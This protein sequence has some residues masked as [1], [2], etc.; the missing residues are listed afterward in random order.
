M[1]EIELQR[2]EKIRRIQEEGKFAVPIEDGEAFVT[3]D[4]PD[5]IQFITDSELLNNPSKFAQELAKK[6]PVISVCAG[7]RLTT[8]TDFGYSPEES[9]SVYCVMFP[10]RINKSTGNHMMEQLRVDYVL[11]TSEGNHKKNR[12]D[13]AYDR[14]PLDSAD[15][16]EGSCGLCLCV[17][18]K[19]GLPHIVSAADIKY[20]A[21]EGAHFT[22]EKG[23]NI[24]ITADAVKYFI[25]NAEK[26]SD[27]DSQKILL[28]GYDGPVD[29]EIVEQSDGSFL[30]R[31]PPAIVSA[32]EL[33][34]NTMLK[35]HASRV[36]VEIA[37]FASNG[38]FAGGSLFLA[39]SFI[40]LLAQASKVSPDV[41]AGCTI[42]P[43]LL[44][45]INRVNPLSLFGMKVVTWFRGKGILELIKLAKCFSKGI[46]LYPVDENKISVIQYIDGKKIYFRGGF[47]ADTFETPGRYIA[48]KT[49][50]LLYS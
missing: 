50:T 7:T 20:P 22:Y 12:A 21:T 44:R 30:Q 5:S 49:L 38:E 31:T 23:G 32:G 15:V 16:F 37:Q 4:I 14:N 33:P 39:T 2:I 19:D 6:E 11:S 3:C 41:R 13:S 27:I 34:M 29:L 24:P 45:S 26:F 43:M 25:R 36:L 46:S 47:N 10:K 42:S 40:E 48:S 28:Y 35:K 17:I 18:G 1:T 9:V 8:L